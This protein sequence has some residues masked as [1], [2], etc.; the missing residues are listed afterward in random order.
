MQPEYKQID[1]KLGLNPCKI[2]D[3]EG[4]LQLYNSPTWKMEVV[5]VDKV[6]FECVICNT[7]KV[8]K[9]IP[10]KVLL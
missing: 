8:F 4:I 10:E 1:L 3:T 6:K 5:Q 9:I 7:C 2:H